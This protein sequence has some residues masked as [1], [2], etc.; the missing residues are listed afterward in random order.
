MGF[1]NK[2]EILKQI[3][4]AAKVYDKELCDKELLIL[5]KESKKD[6]GFCTVEFLPGNF[7]Y[8][9]GTKSHVSPVRF[10]KMALNGKLAIKDFE[11]KYDQYTISK[12]MS[13]ISS[14]M[15]LPNN[16]KIIGAYQGATKCLQ[17]DWGAGNINYVLTLRNDENN[18]QKYV[19][20]G[21][22]MEN[23]QE[24]TSNKA[25]IAIL[26]KEINKVNM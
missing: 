1:E 13:I 25:I 17:A 7:Q 4:L 14:V 18:Y 21:I 15:N 6:I 3:V 19:P 11:L 23:A 24:V 5:Y 2:N 12:K 26:R 20:L 16:A 10:Y 8:F 22:N 9:T